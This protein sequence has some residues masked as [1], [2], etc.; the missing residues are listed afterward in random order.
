MFTASLLNHN[1]NIQYYDSIANYRVDCLEDSPTV[2]APR[3]VAYQ[4][5]RYALRTQLLVYT[6]EVNYFRPSSVD[7]EH[8]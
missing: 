8:T 1:I 6:E 2:D 3:H 4:H 5:R 7:Y